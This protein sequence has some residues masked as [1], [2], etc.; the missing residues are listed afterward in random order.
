MPSKADIDPAQ[1]KRLLAGVVVMEA[2]FPSA[3]YIVRVVGENIVD[4]FGAHDERAPRS[5][6]ET[7]RALPRLHAAA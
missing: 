2:G 5:I 3:R 1:L 4:L 7:A 6:A